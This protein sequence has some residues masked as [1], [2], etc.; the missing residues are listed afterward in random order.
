MNKPIAVIIGDVHFTPSTLELATQAFTQ[1]KDAA[2]LHCIPLIVNGDTLDTKA[3]MRAE[4]VNRLIEL[5]NDDT[6][7]IIFNVGNHDLVSEKGAEHTLN[8]LKPYCDVVAFPNYYSDEDLYIIPYQASLERFQD[9]V[10]EAP[11]SATIV[12][13]Q[14]I[15]TA[16]LGHYIQDKTSAHPSIFEGRRVIGSH[17]HRRQ[18]IKC[19][20]T[21][22]FDYI[23]NPYTLTFGEAQ[24]GPKGFILLYKDKQEFCEVYVRKHVLIETSLEGLK[25]IK[26]DTRDLIHIKIHG[27]Y[28]Q[29]KQ[30]KK[31]DIGK[32]LGHNNFKLDLIYEDKE[33][34]SPIEN[35]STEQIFDKV[36]DE[37]VKDKD[38]STKLKSLW[39]QLLET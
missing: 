5:V 9:Y 17:Y 37:N 11:Q 36:I 10:K 31:E 8:F 2:R 18:H 28:S 39:R 27:E 22:T 29:L 16:H 30:L 25:S 19:G 12:V 7:E 32:I 33:E 3:L 4:C 21:G 35:L 26:V 6:V 14:G 23:G 38:K 1:A 34:P 24:D 15:Q 20:E 13:H